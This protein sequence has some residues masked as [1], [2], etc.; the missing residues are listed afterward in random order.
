[1]HLLEGG[2]DIWT[3][4]ELLGHKGVSTTRMYRHVLNKGGHGMRSPID[5]L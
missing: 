2:Y 3:I 5:G 1:M 4:Q